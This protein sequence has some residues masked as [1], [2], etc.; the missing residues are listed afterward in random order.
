MIMIQLSIL[1][2]KAVN[3]QKVLNVKKVDFLKYLWW[4]GLFNITVKIYSDNFTIANKVIY[5]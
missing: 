4:L 5:P 1:N 3:E 2:E